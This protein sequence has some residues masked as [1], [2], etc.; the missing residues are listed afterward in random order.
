MA[1]TLYPENMELKLN[2]FWLFTKSSMLSVRISMHS[3]SSIKLLLP[4]LK[5][6]RIYR[7]AA[8]Y[9]RR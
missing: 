9:P 6:S 8:A 3:P 5:T 4:A 1:I 2:Y 7:G